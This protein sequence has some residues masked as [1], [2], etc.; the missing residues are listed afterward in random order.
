MVRCRSSLLAAY[1]MASTASAISS[2]AMGPTMCTPRI[3]SSSRAATIF[4]KPAGCSRARARPLARNGN[5]PLLYSRPLALTC[6]S[7]SP[8]QAISGQA[9]SALAVL[10]GDRDRTPRDRSARDLGAEA[11]IEAELL[12]VPQRLAGELL[13]GERQEVRQRFQH[14]DLRSEPAPHAPELESD[15][16]RADDA[17]PLR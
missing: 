8:T 11:D 17:E 15:H 12:E 10:V 6:S 5:T 4:A 14:H 7:V 13:V 9:L 3:S 16:A 2:P 1:S